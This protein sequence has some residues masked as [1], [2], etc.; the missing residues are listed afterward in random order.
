MRFS[1]LTLAVSLLLAWPASESLAD[2]NPGAAPTGRKT[3]SLTILPSEGGYADGKQWQHARVTDTDP[4]LPRVLLIGDSIANG[5]HRQVADALKGVA[6]LDLWITPKN[7]ANPEMIPHLRA[8]LKHGPYA[9]VHFNECGLHAWQTNAVP[10]DQYGPHFAQFVSALKTDAGAAKL[11]WASSTPVTVK[12]KPAELDAEVNATVVEHNRAA[13]AV[14]E[15]QQIVVN[16]L[17]SLMLAKLELARGDR[18]H[19]TAPGQRIQASA[20]ASAIRDALPA[21][22][23]TA[24]AT[25]PPNVLLI[26]ADDMGYGDLPAFNPDSKIVTPA[27]T[28]LASEGMRFTDAHA[29]GSVCVP[30]RYGLVTG[31]FPFRNIGNANPGNGPLIEPD[32]PTISS[33]LRDAGYA[34]AMIGKWHLGFEGGDKF[35]YFKSIRGGPF[36]RGFDWFF[37]QHASLDIPP[38]FYL[39]NDRAVVPATN[40][41]SPRNSPGW[42]DIQ[43]EFWRAG[44]IAPG[45]EMN[46]VLPTYTRKAVEHIQAHARRADRKPFFLYL[47]FTAPHTPWLPPEK[48]RGRSGAGMYGD[49]VMQV[50]DAVGQVLAALDR[51]RLATNTLVIFTS[52]N[53]PVWYPADAERFHHRSAGPFRGMKGDAWEGGHR[54]PLIARWPGKVAPGTTCGETICFTD[55]LATFAAVGGVKVPAGAGEDSHDFSPLLRGQKLE[56]PLR[57][58]TVHQA[59]GTALRSI[60]VGDWKFIPHPGSGGF[61]KPSLVKPAAGEPAGQLYNLADDPGESRNRYADNPEMVAR[62]SALLAQEVNRSRPATKP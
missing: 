20:V 26:L 50:D 12:E 53:G 58:F 22:S 44:K 4:K 17:Y 55:F 3:N 62:L 1:S 2:Q 37:G 19:W 30:S 61:S 13:R 36:D 49:F 31:R 23:T 40:S 25:V 42:T 47:A 57:A 27:L 8:V 45:Y 28:R 11:I 43:G 16:D 33:V 7:V 34:T 52:D 38:Y 51:A 41:I 32:R 18:W 5:Y 29:P 35:D 10:K 15:A 6:N 14:A 48:F 9:V 24:A 39:E 46:D 21:T 54:M 56:R 60:R 59:S